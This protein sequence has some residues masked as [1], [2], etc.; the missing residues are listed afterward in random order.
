VLSRIGIFCAKASS[1][2][3]V[4]VPMD[5]KSDYMKIAAILKKK[6]IVNISGSNIKSH[7]SGRSGNKVA[8]IYEVL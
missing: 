1:R 8:V 3:S 5:Y 6:S 4:L 7:R 2:V